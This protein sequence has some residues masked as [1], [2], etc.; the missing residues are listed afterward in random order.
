MV[1][2]GAAGQGSRGETAAHQPVTGRHHGGS[3][4]R[5][6]P[7]GLGVVGQGGAADR[8]DRTADPGCRRG[9]AD[10][11][12]G[13]VPF[14]WGPGAWDRREAAAAGHSRRDEVQATV[15]RVTGELAG[16]A[17]RACADADRLLANARRALRRAERKASQLKG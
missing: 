12:S 5:G 9:G 8:S 7:D 1:E 15:V 11:A 10:S 2:Q 6:L 14:G 4:E 13:P 16:L 17:E 3:G